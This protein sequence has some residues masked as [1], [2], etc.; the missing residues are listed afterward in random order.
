MYV[1]ESLVSFKKPKNYTDGAVP[2]YMRITV[3]GERIEILTSL[4]CQP[5]NWLKNAECSGGRSSIG[6]DLN[7]HLYAL[8]QKIFNLRRYLIE[9][10]KAVTAK[11]IR[12][13]L[14]S[15]EEKPRMILKIFQQHNDRMEALVG[16]GYAAGTLERYKTSLEHTRSFIKW[17]YSKINY[18]VNKIDFEFVTD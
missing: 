16:L 2:I 12:Q 14:T 18:P 4:K 6:K 7:N 10:D 8:C 1:Q 9:F 17:K 3:D 11:S 13:Y 15:Q 5:E